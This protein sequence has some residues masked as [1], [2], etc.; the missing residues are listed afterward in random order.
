MARAVTNRT[1]AGATPLVR[2][3]GFTNAEFAVNSADLRTQVYNHWDGSSLSPP[4]SRPGTENALSASGP[5]LDILAWSDG[6]PRFPQAL[7]NR[8]AE[9]SSERNELLKVKKVL[10]QKFPAATQPAPAQGRTA[11]VGGVCDYTLDGNREPLDVSRI[12]DLPVVPAADFQVA[13]QDL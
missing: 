8:F 11:R 5:S 12:I 10:E 1:L 2:Y 9:G 6:C 3:F 7:L 13:R 4:R